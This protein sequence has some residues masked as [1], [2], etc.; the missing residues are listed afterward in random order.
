LFTGVVTP[1]WTVV[2][3]LIDVPADLVIDVEIPLGVVGLAEPPRSELLF[4]AGP[5]PPAPGTRPNGEPPLPGLPPT[6]VL[7]VGPCAQTRAPPRP[8]TPATSTN[9]ASARYRVLI[10]TLLGP[11]PNVASW[12]RGSTSNG[13]NIGATQGPQLTGIIEIACLAQYR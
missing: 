4:E 8:T 3:K 10:A 1:R 11:R 5:L 13:V 6:G 7:I 12:Q 2:V 9:R